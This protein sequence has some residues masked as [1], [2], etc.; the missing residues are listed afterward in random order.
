MSS[1]ARPELAHLLNGLHAGD[2]PVMV[3][4]DWLARSLSHLLAVIERVRAA[5]GHFRTPWTK[6]LDVQTSGMPDLLETA[7][8]TPHTLARTLAPSR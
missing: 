4:I 2:T 8:L 6:D 1:R 3:R 5:G 7:Q